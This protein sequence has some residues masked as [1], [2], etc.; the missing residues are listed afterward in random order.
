[1]INWL[2]QN[3]I[4]YPTNGLKPEIYNIIKLNK[5][6]PIYKTDVLAEAQGH[7]VLRLPVRH[8]ELSPIGLCWA[9]CKDH[10]AKYNKSSKFSGR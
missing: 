4:S 9:Y 5:P 3:K 8:C 7:V 6:K 10:I 2:N 1:M